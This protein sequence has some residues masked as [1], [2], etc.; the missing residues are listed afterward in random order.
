MGNATSIF[1]LMRN[2]GGSFGI[3]IMTTFLA[4]RTQLHQSRL[5]EH[6]TLSNPATQRVLHGAQAYFQTRGFDA[7]TAYRKALGVLYGMVQRQA[8]M[9]SFVEAFWVM[10]LVFIF[11]VPFL[12]LL[13][14]SKAAVAV[15]VAPG[16]EQAPAAAS[17]A[18]QPAA[19]EEIP[20]EH[21]L[22]S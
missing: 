16:A 3:A 5:G 13:R 10:G 6:V 21:S 7:Y 17:Q 18:E 2:I 19:N 8:S 15:P 11:M 4:R 9:L 14:Y 1:N 20:Q 12:L 22:V